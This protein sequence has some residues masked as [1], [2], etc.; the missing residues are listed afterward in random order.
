MAANAKLNKISYPVYKEFG[1]DTSNMEEEIV[2]LNYKLKGEC[3]LK[4][5]DW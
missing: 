3:G 5:M 2:P 4:R 1:L